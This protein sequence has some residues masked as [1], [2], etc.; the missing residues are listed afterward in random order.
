MKMGEVIGACE[1]GQATSAPRRAF[2]GA[3]LLSYLR[4]LSPRIFKDTPFG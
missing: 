3:F 2:I 1:G 4:D